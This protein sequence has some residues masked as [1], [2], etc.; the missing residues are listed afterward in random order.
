M[1]FFLKEK[2]LRI[3]RILVGIFLVASEPIDLEEE[4]SAKKTEIEDTDVQ[5]DFYLLFDEGTR[6]RKCPDFFGEKTSDEEYNQTMKCSKLT[7]IPVKPSFSGMGS[8][9][10]PCPRTERKVSGQGSKTPK[11]KLTPAPNHQN[12]R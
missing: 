10:S 3:V 4:K 6:K 9:G 11:E 1:V 7:K 8:Q 12:K 2:F 5:E